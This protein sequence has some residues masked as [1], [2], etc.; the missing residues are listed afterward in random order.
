MKAGFAKL[1]ITPRES[2][3][4]VGYSF[5]RRVFSG[6]P[7]DV[8][9]HL[10]VRS[11]AIRA[12]DESL[13]VVVSLDLAVLP[14]PVATRIRADVAEEL[15]TTPGHVIVACTHT[16]SGPFVELSG[17]E[18][19]LRLTDQD[20]AESN[21]RYGD[22]VREAVLTSATRASGLMYPVEPSTREFALEAGYCRRIPD[23]GSVKHCWGPQE[24]PD[25]PP[26]RHPDP[27]CSLLMLRQTNGDRRFVLWGL[28]MHA[29]VLGKTSAVVSS[30]WPG[31]AC[32]LIESA[33]PGCRALFLQGAGGEIHPWIATQ[34]DPSGVET[35]ARAAAGPVALALQATS[36]E[37][38]ARVSVAEEPFRAHGHEFPVVVWGIG[39]ANLVALPVELF[40]VLGSAIRA[41][42]PGPLLLA[43]LANG[44]EGYWPDRLAFEQGQYE[45]DIARRLGWEPG[46][47]EKLAKHVTTMIGG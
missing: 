22:L 44:W 20:R 16:H 18:T 24:W 47:G 30:D 21:Q 34:E 2:C 26:R 19:P 46:D 4:L 42:A 9:S 38:N 7:A 31:R 41:A 32:D 12:G 5:P 13:L 25:R 1:D 35:V 23:G 40:A 37:R 28:G 33:D 11:L 43:T 39:S 45:P 6:D 3:P 36:I 8:H 17:V 29:V 10:Y 15:D 27:T 14:T